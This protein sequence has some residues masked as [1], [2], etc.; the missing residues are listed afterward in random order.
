MQQIRRGI[1]EDI[2]TL[3]ALLENLDLMVPAIERHLANRERALRNVPPGPAV[4]MAARAMALRAF[5]RVTPRKAE[6]VLFEYLFKEWWPK[7]FSRRMKNPQW[8]NTL[9]AMRDFR[10][11][12]ANPVNAGVGGV[13][14][15]T[16]HQNSESFPGLRSELEEIRKVLRQAFPALVERM[17]SKEKR[18]SHMEHLADLSKR[19]FPGLD[20][21]VK[22]ALHSPQ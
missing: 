6:E 10:A 15:E 20:E 21:E 16:F 13:A 11:S 12:L 14:L 9:Q 22:E 8:K 18:K 5:P 7:L 1:R 4:Y 3:K 2:A 17:M 19:F